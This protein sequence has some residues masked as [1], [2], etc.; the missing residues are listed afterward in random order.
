MREIEFGWRLRRPFARSLSG[1][2]REAGAFRA[3]H[4]HHLQ[5]TASRRAIGMAPFSS[6][7]SSKRPRQISRLAWNIALIGAVPGSIGSSRQPWQGSRPIDPVEPPRKWPPPCVPQLT[8]AV[9]AHHATGSYGR[10]RAI[11]RLFERGHYS[12]PLLGRHVFH[13]ARNRP[14]IGKAVM[15]L[16]QM[17]C[18]CD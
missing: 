7:S 16:L 14:C 9:V 15:L 6:R 13:H 17:I 10:D 11:P 4:R 18:N 8:G 2:E 3:M 1:S 12:P 5:T